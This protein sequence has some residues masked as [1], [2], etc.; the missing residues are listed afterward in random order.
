MGSRFVLGI[1]GSSYSHPTAIGTAVVP[2]DF[3]KLK[4]INDGERLIPEMHD[5]ES[6]TTKNHTDGQS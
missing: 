6:L 5:G 2:T 1:A 3:Y 4:H